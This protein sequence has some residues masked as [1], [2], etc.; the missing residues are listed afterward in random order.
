MTQKSTSRSSKKTARQRKKKASGSWLG[1]F[2]KLSM[3]A[4]VVLAGVL[5]YLDAIVQEKFSGKRWTVP[6][7]VYARPL[8]LFAG[9]K[10]NK[11]DLLVELNALGYRNESSAKSAGAVSINGNTV[12]LH[13]RGFQFYEGAEPAQALRV[14]FSGNS[15]ASLAQ[16]N[17]NPLAVA[18]LEPLVVGGLYPAHKEDRILI[19]LEQVPDLLPQALIAVED[20]DFYTHHGVSLKSIARALWVN[21]SSGSLRQGGSTLTQQLVKNFFLSNERTLTRKVT[22]ALMSILI[23][24]HYNKEEILEA[25][26]NEVFLGQDG[27]RAV[28]GF[29]LASQYFFSQ[30]LAELKLHQ[31]ALLVGMVKGPSYYNPRRQ[32][33]RALERRNL[34][35]DLLAEQ[36]V[37]ALEQANHAKLQPLSI[38]TRGSLANTTYPGFV[39]LVKRQLREDY[40]DQDLTEEGLRIFTSFDPIL[41]R[42]AEEALAQTYKQLAGRR[43][44]DDVESAML[45]SNPESGEVLALLGSRLPRYAGFNRALDAVRP[46]GSLVKPAIYLAA[47]EQPSQYTLT[48]Y[49]Q[50]QSF[51]VKSKNG[52][53]WTPQN[54]DRKE[55]GT[56]F[57]YQG[58]AQSYNLSTAKLGLEMGVPRVLETLRKLGV[59][60]EWP[61][62]PSMLLGAGGLTP[63]EVAGMYQTIANGGFNTPLR[64]IRSVLTAEGEPL[65]RYPYMVEQRFDAGAV[66][67]TQEAMRRVMTEGTGRSVYNRVPSSVVLAGKTG[68]SNDLRDSWFAGFGQD[69]LAVVWMGRDD[70]GKT[71]LTG[72]S[73]AM[74]VWANFMYTAAPRSLNMTPPDNVVMAWVDAYSG[75]GSAQGCPGAVQMPYI[76]GSEPLVGESCDKPIFESAPA[77]SVKSWIRSWLN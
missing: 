76:R 43:G 16:I 52:Q 71:P 50:D 5:M 21:T 47:L 70:N 45:V 41:Q 39:D 12:E 31:V 44:I 2:V 54:Y 14:R 36:G 69:L 58:L 11:Q 38:T 3:V 32:P 65:G 29:G 8:E 25:Y 9:Q 20:R 7:K 51:S 23:E 34:V 15:V 13:T 1:L 40:R 4:V 73:G 37:V 68:T 26:L 59:E 74:Q 33:E 18:R 53:V 75:L 10:L 67:L 6:A 56:V 63:I 28:H 60:R 64:A 19:R 48:H 72:A 61:A 57:L 62:Y 22:E 55:H 46:I 66:Y 24:V 77:E 35:I 49:I 17:G 42:K 27:Q 30:P